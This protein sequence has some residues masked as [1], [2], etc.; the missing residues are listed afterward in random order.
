M[1]FHLSTLETTPPSR[2]CQEKTHENQDLLTQV[3]TKELNRSG[4]SLT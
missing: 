4:G 3:R 1:G 2:A